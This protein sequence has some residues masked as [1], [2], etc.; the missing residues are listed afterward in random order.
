MNNLNRSALVGLLFVA[1]G[2]ILV[3]DNLRIIPWQFA[4]YVFQWE[5]IL[6]AIGA[7]LAI[8]GHNRK[9]GY[10][11]I[12][13]GVIFSLEE[14]FRV[15]LSIWDLWP[16]VF[17]LIGISILTRHRK[18]SEQ[19]DRATVGS[20]SDT[21]DDTAIFGGGD[22]LI[23][24]QNFKGGTLTAIFG[25]SN[26]DLTQAE[27]A[28]GKHVIDVFYMFGGTKIRVPQGWKVIVNVTGVF[29]GMDDKRKFVDVD[30]LTD[31][32]L[33]I[34]GTAIFGGAEIIN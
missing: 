25:G 17:I 23:T 32:E 20:D 18:G 28:E 21:I 3:L 16:A 2:T 26:I 5:N 11:L 30:Q 31:K 6:I 24:T 19:F 13:V 9:T 34:K 29:G 33:H 15:D 4:Y 14:W 7:I 22:R 10:I 27:L 1:I 8:S 12:G